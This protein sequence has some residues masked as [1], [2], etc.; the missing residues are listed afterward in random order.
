[1][2]DVF[3][4]NIILATTIF[5]SFVGGSAKI[6]KLFFRDFHVAASVWHPVP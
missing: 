3:C 6:L 4:R 2:T 1:M 5:R